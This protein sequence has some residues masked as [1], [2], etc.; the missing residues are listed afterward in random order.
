[1]PIR[2]R[3]RPDAKSHFRKLLSEHPVTSHESVQSSS[4]SSESFLEMGVSVSTWMDGLRSMAWDMSRVGGRMRFGGLG[5][6]GRLRS[7]PIGNGGRRRPLERGGVEVE[8]RR[9]LFRVIALDQEVL[10]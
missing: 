4:S 3:A 2:S 7:L 10:L 6:R 1:M 9:K 8:R 5:D